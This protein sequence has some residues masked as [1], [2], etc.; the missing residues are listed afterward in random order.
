MYANEI[1]TGRNWYTADRAK[2]VTFNDCARAEL[3]WNDGGYAYSLFDTEAE[4]RQYL[5]E[6]GF[7][8]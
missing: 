2:L 1:A 4:A 5:R 8:A 7:N 3:H 6:H